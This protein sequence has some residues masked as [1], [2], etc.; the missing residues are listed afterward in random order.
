[1]YQESDSDL[2]ERLVGN[3]IY[4]DTLH[5]ASDNRTSQ[6]ESYDVLHHDVGTVKGEIP[7]GIYETIGNNLRSQPNRTDGR[8]TEMQQTDDAS[9]SV[10]AK[11]GSEG[12]SEY[13]D[14]DIMQ[15]GSGVNDEELRS[16]YA[17]IK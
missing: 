13:A 16:P 4:S 9:S 5:E 15:V 14:G 8:D 10:Y 2:D 6:G 7:T 11:L 3:P 17:T 12:V 1:M